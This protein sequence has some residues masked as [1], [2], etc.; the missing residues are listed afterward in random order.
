MPVTVEASSNAAAAAAMSLNSHLHPAFMSPYLPTGSP[1]TPTQINPQLQMLAGAY[2]ATP[3][4]LAA[5]EELLR[6][7]GYGAFIQ[8]AA[9][10]VKK[11]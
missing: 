10:T 4:Q 7:N 8:G 1:T 9:K 6:Q 11:N 5:Y 2:A 3:V